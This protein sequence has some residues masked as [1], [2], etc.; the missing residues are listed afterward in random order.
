MASRVRL[1]DEQN[2]RLDQSERGPD[3]TTLLASRV[4]DVAGQDGKWAKATGDN[5]RNR[6]EGEE[7]GERRMRTGS[8]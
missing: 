2:H 6:G 8:G 1:I 3:C 4:R 7:G 5:K